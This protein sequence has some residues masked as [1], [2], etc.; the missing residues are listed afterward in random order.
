MVFLY[1]NGLMDHLC[2]CVNGLA[3][4]PKTSPH[5]YKRQTVRFTGTFDAMIKIAR[6]EGLTSLWS[7]LPPTLVMAIPAT[8]VYFTCYEQLRRILEYRLVYLFS[9]CTFCKNCSILAVIAK[10]VPSLA[11]KEVQTSL[12]QPVK[13]QTCLHSVSGFLTWL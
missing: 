9:T 10:A 7:G 3:P 1:C 13:K 4:S 8:V 12:R 2:P 11:V 5:W 6:Y